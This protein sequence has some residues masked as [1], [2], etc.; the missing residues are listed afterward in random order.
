MFISALTRLLHTGQKFLEKNVKVC[1][2]I[3][4]YRS[5]CYEQI[6]DLSF[7]QYKTQLRST[8]LSVDMDV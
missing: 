7:N 3:S 8:L 5:H 6:F 2:P 1:S 4:K